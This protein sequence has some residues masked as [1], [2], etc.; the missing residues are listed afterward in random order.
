MDS[1]ASTVSCN[2]IVPGWTDFRKLISLNVS[3]PT[4]VGNCRTVPSSFTD[5]NVVHVVLRNIKRMLQNIGQ[6]E[7]SITVDQSIYQIAK[8][9]QW[10]DPSLANIIIQ[11]GGFHIAKNFIGVIGKRMKQSGFADILEA[12]SI[13]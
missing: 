2:Q 7:I 10:V 8:E 12:Y 1:F 9:I 6:S 3:F 13:S 4:T 11:L 5:L